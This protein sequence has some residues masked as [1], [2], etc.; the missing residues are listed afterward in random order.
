MA[1]SARRAR[2]G[3]G[4][5]RKLPSGRLQA[6]YTG[7]DT[8]RHVGPVTFDT[9]VDAEAWLVAERR[10]ISE[11]RWLSPTAR[12]QMSHRI[13]TFGDYAERW[14]DR[15]TL[16]PR[17]RWDYRT[18]L[19]RFLLP[20]FGTMAL[21]LITPAQ[22]AAWHHDLAARTGPTMRAH[23]YSLMRTICRTAIDDDEIAVSPCRIRGAGSVKRQVKI[24]P[25]TLDQL[26]TIVEAMPARYRAM[27]LLSSWCALRFGEAAELRRR[28]VDLKTGVLHIR[29]G[30]TW[31]DG[32]PVVGTPKSSAGSRDVA[33]PPHLLPMLRTHLAEHTAFG[34][35]SLLFPAASGGHLKQ[36]TLARVYYPARAKAGRHDLRWHDLRHTGAVL[37]AQSG[38]TLAE[39]MLRLGHSTP[40]AAMIYQHATSDRDAAIAARLSEIAG[41]RP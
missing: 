30:V 13:V 7:P 34:K 38:A 20:E 29:R 1:A 22:V 6:Y 25:A 5:I 8:L 12:A 19:D 17:T 11:D 3:F 15:R 14:L 21:P 2:R 18:L 24:E 40:A 16:K 31:V 28:D 41:G 33:V 39:L 4:G 27:V 9:R 37:A 35:D 26:Q 23:A 32:Q 36:S 10:L